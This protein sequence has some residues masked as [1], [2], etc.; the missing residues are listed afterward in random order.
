MIFETLNKRMYMK[1]K[2]KKWKKEKKEKK[3]V[4]STILWSILTIIYSK[5]GLKIV[6]RKK[7]MK[8]KKEK[9][10]KIY[11]SFINMYLFLISFVSI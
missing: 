8:K 9:K 1:K 11:I 10:I 6:L 7:K 5:N 4:N 3:N 2:K